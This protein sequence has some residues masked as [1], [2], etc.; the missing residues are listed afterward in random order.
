[1][2]RIRL[3]SAI[4]AAALAAVAL[5]LLSA[6]ATGSYDG[7]WQMNAAGAGKA[8]NSGKYLCPPLHVTLNVQDGKF[9]GSLERAYGDNV[10]NGYDKNASAVIGTVDDTGVVKLN[11]QD[12]VATGTATEHHMTISWQGE[13]GPRTAMGDIY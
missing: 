9:T 7:T 12:V 5:P 2:T 1:M 3:I 8:D 4:G 10:V 11:W 13:C 6:Q